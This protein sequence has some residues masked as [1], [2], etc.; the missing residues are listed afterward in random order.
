MEFKLVSL[1][2]KVEEQLGLGLVRQ[3]NKCFIKS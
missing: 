2:Q 1:L 3:V